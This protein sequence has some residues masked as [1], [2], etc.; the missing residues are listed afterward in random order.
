MP[1]NVEILKVEPV[2][3][4]VRRFTVRKPQDYRFEPGQ[5]TLVSIDRPDWQKKKRPFTFTS[6]ND[7]PDLEFTTK[8]YPDHHGVTKIQ[9][10]ETA[11]ILAEVK[12][13]L[14]AAGS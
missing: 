9:G 1:H 11:R 5:A 14:A 13:E 4:N 2:T 10:S 12:A 3:H 6:L 7:W 8:I